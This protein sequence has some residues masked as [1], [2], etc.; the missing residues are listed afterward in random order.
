MDIFKVV[1]CAKF[2]TKVTDLT[3]NLSIHAYFSWLS[4]HLVTNK[5]IMTLGKPCD[6]NLHHFQAWNKHG[7]YLVQGC[8]Q[9][10]A[11]HAQIFGISSY[12]MNISWTS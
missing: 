2:K 10:G 6:N 8:R 1:F 11:W 4:G 9:V 12:V 7:A 3:I 5:T